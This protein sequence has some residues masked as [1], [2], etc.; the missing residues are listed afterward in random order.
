VRWPGGSSNRG[1]WRV[2]LLEAVRARHS[3]VDPISRAATLRPFTNPRVNCMF[4]RRAQKALNNKPQHLQ[5]R[6]NVLAASSSTTAWFIARPPAD[7]DHWRHV[8]L[9]SLCLGLG[10]AFFLKAEDQERFADD[11]HGCRAAPLQRV[12]PGGAR[13]SGMRWSNPRYEACNPA[14]PDFN[15][16]AEGVAITHR[17]TTTRRRLSSAGL[18]SPGSQPSEPD[19]LNH[20]HAHPSLFEGGPPSGSNTVHRV[21]K[22]RMGRA[23]SSIVS[24]APTARPPSAAA[25]FRAP[26]PPIS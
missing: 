12:S 17:R 25:A 18:I 5:P 15:A 4:E 16:P 14:N 7:Y 1:R 23:A 24:A 2:L 13:R 20:A 19:H 26:G 11:F 22:G 9:R 10:I 3:T 6:C 8:R 21:A